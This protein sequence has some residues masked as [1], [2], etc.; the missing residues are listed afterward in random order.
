MAW[1]FSRQVEVKENPVGGAF[2]QGVP[3]AQPS[4]V[5]PRAFIK[6]GYQ[7]NVVVY[8]AIREIVSA[9]A[10]IRV[11][12]YSGDTLIETHPALDLLNNPNPSQSYSAWLSEM[13]VNH[14]LQ[15][16]AFAVAAGS[17]NPKTPPTEMWPL[18]PVDMAVMPG[19]GGMPS[20]FKHQR[21][22]KEQ[23]FPADRMTGESQV[24]F[25]KTY[26]P[27]S[28]WRGQSPL[29]AAGVAADT[30]NAG[31][32]WNLSLLKNSAR[33]S[34]LIRFKGGY[35]GD[36]VIQRMREYFKRGM[37][38]ESNA[39]EIP[40]LADD[41]EWVQLSQ[42]ARD[43]DFL[44]TMKESAKYIASAY[45]VPLPLIDNDA[46]TFNNLQQA[47][48][49]FYTDTVIPLLEEFM[50]DLG[51][52]L[53]PRYGEGLEFRLDLDSIPALEGI[54]QTRFDRAI[55]AATA[56]LITREEAREMMGFP[57]QPKNGGTFLS[58]AGDPFGMTNDGAKSLIYGDSMDFKA[59]GE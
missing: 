4:M 30:H 31:S 23:E 43:M 2:V 52:W 13:L 49:R 14:R 16:E 54:R 1:P 6:E 39:G 44:N 56:D 20:A 24:F 12:L 32:R 5:N 26:N 34:G 58:D 7:G 25:T 53:L 41:A 33:P 38:G 9:A 17:D 37:Q 57:S 18:N 51:A 10:S 19:T 27:D 35:P 59:D 42:S 47:K 11:E 22:G 15:G 21:G 40:M 8:R 36:Q 45:G 3:V 28:Y 29:M 50:A 55:R 48:E 46:S